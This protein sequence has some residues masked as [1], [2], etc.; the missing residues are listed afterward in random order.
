MNLTDLTRQISGLRGRPVDE[1]TGIVADLADNLATLAE[2]QQVADDTATNLITRA[3]RAIRPRTA[4]PADRHAA[5]SALRQALAEGPRGPGRPATTGPARTVRA[6]VEVWDAVDAYAAAH[7]V[8]ES[9]AAAEL[10]AA[11]LRAQQS[12]DIITR[13]QEES[14]MLLDIA[15]LTRLLGEP[16]HHQEAVYSWTGETDRD[17]RW[18]PDEAAELAKIWA[19]D[20]CP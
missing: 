12:A 10:L 15:D 17:R 9:R 16:D 18:T 2:N 7:G 20:G 1:A 19:A 4:R 14:V 13:Y 8:S 3:V 5:L 11:G 6:P